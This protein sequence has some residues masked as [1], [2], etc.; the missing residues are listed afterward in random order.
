MKHSK[1]LQSSLVAAA[2]LLGVGCKGAGMGVETRTDI[3][4]QMT[5]VQGPIQE[6]YAAA[7]KSNRRIKGVMSLEFIAEAS[8]GQF[9][10]I[11]I[12]RDEVNDVAV[13]QCVLAEVGKLK[14]SKAT[15]SNIQIAY[16]LRFEPNN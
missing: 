1:I 2:L 15:S 12:R 9:K 16:P 11:N 5:S 3:T 4:T 14:L 7:L 10:N 6:C 13:R 8:T